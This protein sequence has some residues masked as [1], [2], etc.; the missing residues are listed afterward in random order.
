MRLLAHCVYLQ[1]H[2]KNLRTWWSAGV[3]QFVNMKMRGLTIKFELHS[4]KET[5]GDTMRART[6]QRGQEVFPVFWCVSACD[7]TWALSWKTVCAF[8][9]SSSRWFTAVIAHVL[10]PKIITY[11]QRIARRVRSILIDRNIRNV[12]NCGRFV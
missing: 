12:Y 5:I 9:I 10:S 3:S 1:T 8:S 7:S 4:E 11:W 2:G 6:C